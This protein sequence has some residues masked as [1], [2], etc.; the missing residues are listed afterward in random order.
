MFG[1]DFALY[2]F[3]SWQQFSFSSLVID[4]AVVQLL[5]HM[6]SNPLVLVEQFIN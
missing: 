6:G 5:Y 4:S 1:L 3:P 2:E